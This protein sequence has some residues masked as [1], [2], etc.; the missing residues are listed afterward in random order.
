MAGA[1]HPVTSWEHQATN[2]A[3][4]GGKAGAPRPVANIALAR[5]A[6]AKKWAAPG[7]PFA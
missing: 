5:A 4:E 3:S 7:H 1:G 2:E 6:K